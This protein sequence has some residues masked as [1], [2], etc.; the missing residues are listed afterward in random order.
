MAEIWSFG[1][2]KD[3]T[4]TYADGTVVPHRAQ[5][6]LLNGRPIGEI[7]IHA[8]KRRGPDGLVDVSYGLTCICY[9]PPPGGK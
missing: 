9:G 2:A 3:S 8:H 4:E 5:L 1:P 6:V 7:E